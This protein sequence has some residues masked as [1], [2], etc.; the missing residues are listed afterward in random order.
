[1]G[2]LYCK[3]LARWLASLRYRYNDY[4]KR[5]QIN[6]TWT[7]GRS[8]EIL[9]DPRLVGSQLQDVDQRPGSTPPRTPVFLSFVSNH[10]LH[11]DGHWNH[12]GVKIVSRNESSE[13]A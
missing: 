1:M 7:D 3:S 8:L 10:Y 5:G 9:P 11:N 6:L 2:R 12:V 13:I 4:P